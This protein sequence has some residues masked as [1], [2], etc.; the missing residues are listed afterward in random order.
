ME[1]TNSYL[2]LFI[3]VLYF[4][5]TH[6]Q[7]HSTKSHIQKSLYFY[8]KSRYLKVCIA[9]T[10]HTIKLCPLWYL[11]RMKTYPK[12]SQI[13]RKTFSYKIRCGVFS[14]I[15]YIFLFLVF[16]FIFIFLYLW[17]CSLIFILCLISSVFVKVYA[18]SAVSILINN[19]LEFITILMW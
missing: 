1:I 16:L 19:T 17:Y 2:F 14:G 8:I 13:R 15:Y 7:A 9:E 4:N 18:R 6:T 11:F 10:S 3:I 5:Y 12:I